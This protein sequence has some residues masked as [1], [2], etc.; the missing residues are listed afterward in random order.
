[1]ETIIVSCIHLALDCGNE[2]NCF[3]KDD[4]DDDDLSQGRECFGKMRRI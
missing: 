3:E 2:L 4:L 1:M